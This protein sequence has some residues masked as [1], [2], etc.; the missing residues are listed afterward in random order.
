MALVV[1]I[2]VCSGSCGKGCHS[3]MYA[4]IVA[5][6]IKKRSNM[7]HICLIGDKKVFPRSIIILARV[8]M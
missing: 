8:G 2:K 4:S 7:F 1:E 6:Q 3:P 5:E